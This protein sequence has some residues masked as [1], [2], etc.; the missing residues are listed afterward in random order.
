MKKQLPKTIENTLI[1]FAVTMVFLVVIA[2]H[3]REIFEMTA[4]E[5]QHAADASHGE[6]PKPEGHGR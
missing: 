6:V 1:I 3:D 5:Y 4:P 2:T